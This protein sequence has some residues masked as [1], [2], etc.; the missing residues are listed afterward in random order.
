MRDYYQFVCGKMALASPY[1]FTEPVA[2]RYFNI[3]ETT[4][5]TGRV[6]AELPRI[7]NQFLNQFAKE[8]KVR[9]SLFALE[10]SVCSIFK[11]SL[12]CVV[13]VVVCRLLRELRVSF[14]CLFQLT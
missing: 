12:Q 14:T 7:A 9:K 1:R 13:I 6:E 4:P 11:F 3:Q 10:I 8:L 2:H 5:L